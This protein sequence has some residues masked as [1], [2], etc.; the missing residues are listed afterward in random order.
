MFLSLCAPA[1]RGPPRLERI[2]RK[3]G[4]VV[5]RFSALERKLAGIEMDNAAPQRRLDNV[6]RRLDCIEPAARCR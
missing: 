3:L 5:T 1:S 2:G 6:D 4:E